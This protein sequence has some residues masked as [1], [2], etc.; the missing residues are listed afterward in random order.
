MNL[1][2]IVLRAKYTHC[3]FQNLNFRESTNTVVS[4][5]VNVANQI[6]VMM[7]AGKRRRRRK[8]KREV[9]RVR[10]GMD[11][12][13]KVIIFPN[14]QIVFLGADQESLK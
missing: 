14:V 10:V 2:N 7:G 4:G 1:G 9:T 13:A 6:N 5:N 12:L 8:R 3:L 11:L